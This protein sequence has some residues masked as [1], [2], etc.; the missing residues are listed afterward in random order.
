MN[1][2]AEGEQRQQ[3]RVTSEDAQEDLDADLLEV[4][5]ARDETRP[6]G[7]DQMPLT[8]SCLDLNSDYRSKQQRRELGPDVFRAVKSTVKKR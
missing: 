6:R 2:D 4:R 5:V 1:D 7:P 3:F 8:T